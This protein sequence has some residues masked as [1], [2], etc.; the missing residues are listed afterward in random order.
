MAGESGGGGGAKLATAYYELI[1]SMGGAQTS[2]ASQ[3]LP[4]A[5]GAG[6]GAGAGI[7]EALLGG[8]K[9]FA[10]PIAI[11]AAGFSIKK[12]V[13]ESTEAFMSLAG[14]VKGLQRITGGTVEQASLL[15]AT[16]KLSGVDTAKASTAMTIFSRNLNSANDGGEKAAAMAAKLGTGF[17]DAAGGIKPI[18]E[19][20]PGL[21]DKFSKMP[22]GAEKTALAMQLFGRSGAQMLPFLNKGAAGL[23]ELQEKARDMGLVLDDTSIKIMSAAKVSLR[24]YNM[25]IQGTK[26]ALG[27]TLMPVMTAFSNVSR[28]L[29]IPVLET[30]T[31]WFARARTPMMEAAET[32]QS[33]AD[34]GGAA[35]KGILG[36]FTGGDSKADLATSLGLD[37]ASPV[38]ETL[39][40]VREGFQSAFGFVRDL[41]AGIGPTI[42]PLVGQFIALWTSISPLSIIFEAIKP[43]LPA[44]ADMFTLLATSLGGAFADVLTVLSPALKDIAGVLAGA[45]G[46][47]FQQI[48]PVLPVIIG[49]VGQ[50]ASVFA[51]VLG[52]ALGIV[53]PIISDLVSMLA[54][55]FSQVLV[56][57]MP[58]VSNLV[59]VLGPVL[60]AVLSALAPLIG[61]LAGVF[62]Q[63]LTAVMPLIE[64][65]LGVAMALLPVLDPIMQ[66]VGALLPPLIDLFMALLGPI[67]Q[68]VPILVGLLVPV[69]SFV[70]TVLSTVVQWLVTAISWLVDLVTGSGDAGEQLAAIWGSTMGMFADFFTNTGGM[71]ADFFTNTIGMFADFGSNLGQTVVGIWN[72]VTAFFANGI[73]GII[74]FVSGLPGQVM[75]ALGNLGTML[76]NAGRD[77]I[78]GLLDGAG[79]LL[80]NIGNF[81]LKIL[82]GWIVEPF[83][84]ALG[85]R[86]PSTVMA[87]AAQWLPAGVVVGVNRGRGAVEAAMANLVQV[88]SMLSNA[89]AS[90]SANLTTTG[91]M[92]ATITLLD[93]DGSIL[94]RAQ[95]IAG[96]A[97]AA[98]DN[99]LASAVRGGLVR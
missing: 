16:L 4:A 45:L 11:L 92:P 77:M 71:F 99:R 43:V 9:K 19:I 49:V 63:V 66:L 76:F 51:G 27:G 23:A 15:G 38:I 21:A 82:P 8:L 70:A 80:R 3:L 68:L 2:I 64:P 37:K 1:P 62:S 31:G 97:V 39:F 40:R 46:G 13:A 81:F 56:T 94:T 48:M 5:A 35:M 67:L 78:Q 28:S 25:T 12:I 29:M 14:E 47:A 22:D 86:S 6:M 69:L 65:L 26:V 50:L 55:T 89:I 36:F 73:A 10:G 90:S 54:G 18:S 72:N 87:D 98:A 30:L 93:R 96:E 79:S 17:L 57:L 83:K 41:I 60:G 52:D 84:A 61:I 20:M 75:G 53:I 7:G 91:G 44:L 32:L 34:R 24:E 85:I 88:P 33:F 58:I 59:G 42:G 95:V 74:G